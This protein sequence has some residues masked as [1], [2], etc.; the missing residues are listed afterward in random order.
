MPRKKK[1]GEARLRA[2]EASKN[3]NLQVNMP[4]IVAKSESR[5]DITN[6]RNIM[7]MLSQS[8]AFII[9]MNKDPQVCMNMINHIGKT[10]KHLEIAINYGNHDVDHFRT[11][12]GTIT[13]AYE[14][15]MNG[16]QIKLVPPIDFSPLEAS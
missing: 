4:R 6:A 8:C 9:S 11:L 16:Y 2:D 15:V 12:I 14:E 3:M 13:T 1:V 10:D 5:E 7:Y